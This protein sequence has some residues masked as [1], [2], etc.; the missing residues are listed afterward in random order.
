MP[1]RT[2]RQTVLS[3]ARQI[4]VKLGTQ[5]LTGSDGKLDA[6]YLEQIVHQIAQLHQC[7]VEVT[8]VSSGA[9]AAGWAELGLPKRPTDVSE[10]QAVAAVGQRLLMTFMHDAFAAHQIHVGQLLLTRSDFDDRTRF[11]NIR[12]CVSRLHRYGGVPIIN[13]NDTVA[14]DELRFGD[15]D[16]LAALICNAIRADALVLLTVVDGILDQHN[17]KVEL[18]DHLQDYESLVRAEMTALGTGG[19]R[20]KLEAAKLVTGAGEVAVIANGREPDVLQR[21]FASTEPIGTVFA[22]AP[23]KL[24]SRKRWIGLTKRPSGT[25]T[26]DS[27]AVTALCRRGKSLLAIGITG[28]SG[29]FERGAVVLVCEQ[30]GSHVARGLSNYSVDELRLL[31]GKRSNQFEKILGRAA[32]AEVVHRDNLVMIG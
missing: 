4:V 6:P 21:L 5:L 10:L 28:L 8:V 18:I 15:N 26:I 20:S 9:I 29:Q 27:G 31:M 13:E 23:R 25:L 11:L 17:Q 32:Y 1:T 2:L 3:S 19:I 12:N 24:D 7:G 22:P 14:V 16:L 30:D